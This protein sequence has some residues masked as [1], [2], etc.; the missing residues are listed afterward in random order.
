MKKCPR[1]NSTGPLHKIHTKMSWLCSFQH[2]LCNDYWW[3]CWEL[4]FLT[5]WPLN[6][7]LNGY[8]GARLVRGRGIVCVGAEIPRKKLGLQTLIDWMELLWCASLFSILIC[9]SMAQNTHFPTLL[10]L[11]L[12]FYSFMLSLSQY[13]PVEFTHSS[14]DAAAE[15]TESEHIMFH[16]EPV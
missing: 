4:G 1:E 13:G 3:I 11:I 6:Q 5:S 2:P 12:S 16:S 7:H 8:Q 10:C 9:V 15:F 14:S